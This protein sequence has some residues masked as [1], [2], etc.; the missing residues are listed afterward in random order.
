MPWVDLGP[1]AANGLTWTLLAVMA[2]ATV[3]WMLRHR[4]VLTT[5]ECLAA[6]IPAVLLASTVTWTHHGVQLLL[7]LAVMTAAVIRAPHLRVLDSGWLALIWLLYTNWPVEEFAVNL[8]AWQAHKR[9]QSQK[10]GQ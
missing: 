2:A 4:H 8:P 1:Q 3:V 6:A 10:C 7:P 9:R 5:G